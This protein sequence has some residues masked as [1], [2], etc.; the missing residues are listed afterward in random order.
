MEMMKLS[1][2]IKSPVA[3]QETQEQEM[4]GDMLQVHLYII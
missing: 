1:K 3:C 2:F 4:P